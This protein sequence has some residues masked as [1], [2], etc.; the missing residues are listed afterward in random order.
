M[1][2]RRQRIRDRRSVVDHA[3]TCRPMWKRQQNASTEQKHKD[4]RQAT[5][6]DDDERLPVR[7]LRHLMT[8]ANSRH[9]LPF[10][11]GSG[12]AGDREHRFNRVRQ[13]HRAAQRFGDTEPPDAPAGASPAQQR[14]SL[15]LLHCSVERCPTLRQARESPLGRVLTPGPAVD[16]RTRRGSPRRVQVARECQHTPWT[17]GAS[18]LGVGT[19]MSAGR[20]RGLRL[21][22]L[23]PVDT[24]R[25]PERFPCPRDPGSVSGCSEYPRLDRSRCR[26]LR[27][28]SFVCAFLE[29][30]GITRFAATRRTR[31]S[32]RS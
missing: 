15:Q 26:P 14:P 11:A 20:G 3:L 17:N 18:L 1:S 16:H 2:N 19:K 29:R 21:V 12:H 27:G 7:D 13:H 22:L 31:I 32:Q 6:Q 5:N 23:G 10:H 28:T 4:D 30:S 24:G 8:M 25:C 9:A